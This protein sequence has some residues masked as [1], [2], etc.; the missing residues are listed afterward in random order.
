LFSA[1]ISFPIGLAGRPRGSGAR[2]LFRLEDGGGL[3]RI[4]KPHLR[5]GK[6][7]AAQ[8]EYNRSAALVS[9]RGP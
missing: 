3:E 2:A 1:F 8:A 4:L 5:G 6:H 9:H 7:N